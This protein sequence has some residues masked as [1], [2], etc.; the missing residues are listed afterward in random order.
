MANLIGFSRCGYLVFLSIKIL[1]FLPQTRYPITISISEYKKQTVMPNMHETKEAHK[2]HQPSPIQV[3]SPGVLTELL[4]ISPDAL[5]VVDHIG[6]IVM[7]NVQMDTLFGYPPAEL[8]G[9]PLE[10]LLPP[11]FREDH[12][13]HR[14][15]YFAAPR[16]RPMGAGLQLFGLRKDGSEFP[17]DI[18]LRPLLLAGSLHILGAVRDV[19]QQRLAE[20][21][22]FQQA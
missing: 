11:R 5:L 14:S 15:R 21:E 2:N 4:N 6:T 20:R 13:S 22:R 3:S 9:Q 1:A 18:S 17:V 7:T 10:M 8:S 19:T 16:H 12:I